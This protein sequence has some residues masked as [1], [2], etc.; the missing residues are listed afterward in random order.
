M[1]QALLHAGQHRLVVARLH[2]DDAIRNEARLRKCGGEEIGTRQAP[3]HLSATPGGHSGAEQSGGGPVDGTV[4]AAGDLMKGP[5]R[6]PPT[7]QARIDPRDSEREDS[8]A[9]SASAL[10]PLDMVAQRP[11][12]GLWPQLDDPS[13]EVSSLFVLSIDLPESSR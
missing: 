2:V 6:Q 9:T 1:A 5:E 13:I 3:K 8:A 11:K 12:C 4:A 7:R 10:D